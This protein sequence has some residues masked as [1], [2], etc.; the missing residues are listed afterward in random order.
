[1]S[2]TV[3]TPAAGYP[4]SVDDLRA[5]IRVTSDAESPY[6]ETCIRAATDRVERELLVAMREQVWRVTAPIEDGIARLPI[7]AR[8][9]SLEAVSAVDTSGAETAMDTEGDVVLTT[10]HPPYRISLKPGKSYPANAVSVSVDL[11]V[12]YPL[13][14]DVPSDLVMLTRF[15]AA[16]LAE[17][18]SPDDTT[19]NAERCWRWLSSGLRA[20]YAV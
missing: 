14:I 9:V 3:I 5:Q 17:T 13:A 2:V 10:I 4:I 1:M 6:Y 11:R 7:A 20:R 12:G 8:V 18:R 16:W 15:Y 19:E